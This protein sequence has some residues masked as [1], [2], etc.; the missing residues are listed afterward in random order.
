MEKSVDSVPCKKLWKRGCLFKPGRGEAGEGGPGLLWVTQRPILGLNGWVPERQVGLRPEKELDS[1]SVVD[2]VELLAN[3]GV[4][5]EIRPSE[6]AE[7]SH[8]GGRYTW[9]P[10]PS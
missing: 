9:S 7:G 10:G 4:A 1:S 5:N 8:C 6:P 2:Q 3:E